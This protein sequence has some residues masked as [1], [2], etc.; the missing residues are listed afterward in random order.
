MSEF[1][2][3]A[4]ADVIIHFFRGN[5]LELLPQIFPK[6]K[7]V[8]LDTVVAELKRGR[9]VYA[10]VQKKIGSQII[11]IDFNDKDHVKDE[12]LQLVG[13]KLG[14]GESACI[15]L[16]R[17]E[18]HH[19][20]SCNLKDI[21]QY[22]KAHRIRIYTTMDLIN[23]AFTKGLLTLDEC[24]DFVTDVVGGGS[25]LPKPTF[26]EY[27]KDLSGKNPWTKYDQ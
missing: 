6:Q 9:N 24:N 22:C 25:N 15:A 5:R 21:N 1:L 7:L 27:L 8:L 14:Y 20:L 18:G 16:A 26:D 17:F 19:V 11:E 23:I 12:W 2:L 4:D 3:L 13:K 10:V